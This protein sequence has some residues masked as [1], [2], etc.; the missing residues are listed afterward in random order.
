MPSPNRKGESARDLELL[1]RLAQVKK[2]SEH[3][4]QWLGET[5]ISYYK[6]TVQKRQTKLSQVA[7]VWGRLVP[8]LLSDHCSLY[9]LSRGTLTVLVNSSS[10][11]YQ[12]RQ[13]LLAGIEKQLMFAAKSAGLRKIVLKPGQW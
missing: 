3:S 2:S 4:P 12:L 5:M 8:D 7:E 11:L 10:H 13:L 6:Q 1:Q 9:S